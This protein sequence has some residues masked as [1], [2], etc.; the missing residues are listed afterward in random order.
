MSGHQPPNTS[1]AQAVA[2]ASGERTAQAKA[3]HGPRLRSSKSPCRVTGRTPACKTMS[4]ARL[5]E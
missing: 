5:P 1:A 4:A 2:I 3:I